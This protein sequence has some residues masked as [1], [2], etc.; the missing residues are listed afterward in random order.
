MSTRSLL[1]VTLAVLFLALPTFAQVDKATI[2]AVALDQS[3]APLPGVT[4]TVSRAETGFSA[5]GVTDTSGIARFLSLA[6]G[7]YS[8]QFALDGFGTVK[9]SHLTLVVGQNAKVAVTM[10]QKASET[11]TVSAAPP[12]VDVHKTD[13]S[14][15]I[16]PEQIEQLPV[17]NRDFQNLAFLTPGVQR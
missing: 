5:V 8:V 15:N 13:S 12:V 14:T 7:V 16:V 9:E 6:P 11:I 17:P 2:E 10:Q 4:V 3:K 1:L